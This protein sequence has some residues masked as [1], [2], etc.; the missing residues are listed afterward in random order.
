MPARIIRP[1]CTRYQSEYRLTVLRIS[2][3]ITCAAA[4]SDIIDMIYLPSSPTIGFR[5]I[6]G[7]L[8]APNS[9]SFVAVSMI[10]SIRRCS[11]LCRSGIFTFVGDAI[12]VPDAFHIALLHQVLQTPQHDHA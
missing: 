6:G 10:M 2:S 5:A 7:H 9:D 4:S 1:P 8:E 11:L 3:R 12:G